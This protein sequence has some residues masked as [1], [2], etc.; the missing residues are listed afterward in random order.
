MLFGRSEFGVAGV[1]QVLRVQFP[2]YDDRVIK[3]LNHT[4]LGGYW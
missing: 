4:A 2:R 3:F 1:R